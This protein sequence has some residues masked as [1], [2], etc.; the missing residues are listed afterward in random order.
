MRTPAGARWR[1][2]LGALVLLMVFLTTPPTGP[3]AQGAAQLRLAAAPSAA[4]APLV[5]TT[6]P[7]V[8]NFPVVLDGVRTLTDGAGQAHFDA[9]VTDED[10]SERVEK[11]EETL[12]I[13]GHQV[14]VRTDRIYPSRTAPLLALDL[15]YL[16][17]F[18][19]LGIDGS[20]MEASSIDRFV[21]KSET[22][23]IA[24]ISPDEPAWLQGSR[25]IKRT[26]LME[27]KNLSWSV[28]RVDYA[29]TNVVNASQQ[30]FLPAEK[31]DIDVGLLF[32]GL[33]VEI[34]DAIYGFSH[35]G[36]V[37]LVYPDGKARRFDLDASGRLTLAA[38]PR[39]DYTLTILASGPKMSRPLAVS[40]DQSVELA[41]YSWLDIATVLGAILAVALGLLWIGRVRRRRARDDDPE[42]P[43][44]H[45]RRR[46]LEQ[47]DGWEEGPPA[48]P[49]TA[50]GLVRAQGR[51]DPQPG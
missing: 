4:R 9:E 31:Q 17:S 22:G 20:P 46:L 27:V 30:R 13:G 44:R 43:R 1:G 25:V 2:G 8:A 36:S 49:E 19:F 51:R 12:T 24:E 10:L 14:L 7:P 50:T 39:G 40:R 35:G 11:T 21:L 23:E 32:F 45:R 3:T 42:P 48:T 34:H 26:G 5:I 47:H 15:S 6:V 16:V 28:Q 37:E 41:F 18:R 38:L 33:G 29:G